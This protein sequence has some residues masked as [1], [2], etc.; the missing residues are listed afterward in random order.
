MHLPRT[1]AFRMPPQREPRGSPRSG[2]PSVARAAQPVPQGATASPFTLSSFL[3]RRTFEGREGP[4]SRHDRT[5]SLT[6]RIIR[7]AT[8][9][10]RLKDGLQ[11]FVAPQSRL[12]SGPSRPS[13]W[14]R[15][16]NGGRMKG[17]A[18]PATQGIVLNGGPLRIKCESPA[19]L[20]RIPNPRGH[21]PTKSVTTRALPPAIARRVR[22]GEHASEGTYRAQAPKRP[23]ATG[24]PTSAPPAMAPARPQPR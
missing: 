13:C 6:E 2:C 4:R 16:R 7:L 15:V 8:H 19:F 5:S 20:R 24:R 10:I 21:V 23:R 14:L 22:A 3:T 1:I 17:L 9:A 18:G 12:L 11:R